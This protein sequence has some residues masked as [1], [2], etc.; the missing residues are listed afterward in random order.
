MSHIRTLVALHQVQDRKHLPTTG[1]EWYQTSV[2]AP[3]TLTLKDLCD[4]KDPHSYFLLTEYHVTISTAVAFT[5]LLKKV[6]HIL[7]NR[8]TINLVNLTID[9]NTETMKID[10][11]G[12]IKF[13]PE[14]REITFRSNRFISIEALLQHPKLKKINITN[15]LMF[16][17][18]DE[19]NSILEKKLH[20]R[21]TIILD[22]FSYQFHYP[23]SGVF[24]YSYILLAML[25]QLGIYM[26]ELA[27]DKS[28]ETGTNR[29]NLQLVITNETASPIF[30]MAVSTILTIALTLFVINRVH[31][32]NREIVR[33]S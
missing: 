17:N 7:N 32:Q 13:F 12:L 31:S 23:P 26:L 4:E 6:P 9:I 3:K 11:P 27:T 29:R 18:N 21:K 24:W 5:E 10:I 25:F 30:L 20:Q 16:L 33:E 1:V 2:A 28:Q 19:K 22:Q 15:G 14:L 8:T